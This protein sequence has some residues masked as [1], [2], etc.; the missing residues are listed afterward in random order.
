MYVGNTADEVVVLAV[1]HGLLGLPGLSARSR[2]HFILPPSPSPISHLASAD[3]K[4]NV[5]LLEIFCK[6]K[7]RHAVEMLDER[8]YIYL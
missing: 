1:V 7:N 2:L 6:K 3:V 5:Y 4:Q 8:D